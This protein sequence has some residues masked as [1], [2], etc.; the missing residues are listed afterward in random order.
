MRFTVRHELLPAN[1]KRLGHVAIDLQSRHLRIANDQIRLTILC[2]HLGPSSRDMG[3]G[4]IS[5]E[6]G[7]WTKDNARIDQDRPYVH[8]LRDTDVLSDPRLSSR[9]A[10]IGCL[11]CTHGNS[12]TPP[13]D[14]DSNVRDDDARREP[15]SGKP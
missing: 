14:P 6:V 13:I 3:Q 1:R 4:L 5:P 7:D 12:S 9:T 2:G 11:A 10:R 15:I 8:A